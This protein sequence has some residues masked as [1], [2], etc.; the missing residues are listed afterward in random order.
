MGDMVHNPDHY[1]QMK[2]TLGVEVIDIIE[3]TYNKDFLLGNALKYLLRAPYKG[4]KT[5][6]LKKCIWY[7]NR[8]LNREEG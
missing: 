1:T 2:K 6:D 7:I 5:Q 3:H 4:N 8:Y